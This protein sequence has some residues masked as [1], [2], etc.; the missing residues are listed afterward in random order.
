MLDLRARSVA[1]EEPRRNVNSSLF[2]PIFQGI[3]HSGFSLALISSCI[4]ATGPLPCD[5]PGEARSRGHGAV[6]D[7]GVVVHLKPEKPSE[8]FT[9]EQVQPTKHLR[10][11]EQPSLLFQHS[12]ETSKQAERGA[13]TSPSPVGAELAPATLRVLASVASVCSLRQLNRCVC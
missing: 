12:S 5:P 1:S 3:L 9:S 7:G 6:K 13:P 2:C 11:E 4:S 10:A 8:T